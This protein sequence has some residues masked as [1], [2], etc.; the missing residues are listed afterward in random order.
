MTEGEKGEGENNS[1]PKFRG[2]TRCI[3]RAAIFHIFSTFLPVMILN[4]MNYGSKL[5]L[6]DRVVGVSVRSGVVLKKKMDCF[7]ITM[8]KWWFFRWETEK[9]EKKKNLTKGP[10]TNNNL[11]SL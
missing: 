5:S 11:K 4:D 10:R 6:Y 3:S 8:W 1:Y 9:P 2:Q 7:S